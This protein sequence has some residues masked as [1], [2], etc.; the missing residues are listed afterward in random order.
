MTESTTG[1]QNESFWVGRSGLVIPGVLIAIGVFLIYGI[2][3]MDV[4]GNDELFGPRAFPAITAGAC[5]IVAAVLAV[6]ILRAPSVPESMINPDGSLRDGTATNWTAT[7]ITVGA[8][9][10]F[11]A[12]LEPLGWIIAGAVVFAGI[13]TGMGNKR[14]LFNL[15]V[16]LAMSSIIQLLFSG[17]LGLNLPAGVM[18]WW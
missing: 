16:G 18:G 10:L 12:I 8:F 11:I 2:I 6:Q 3:D 17:L 1:V 9:V 14:Y 15:M 5:F 13:T 7:G 4:G